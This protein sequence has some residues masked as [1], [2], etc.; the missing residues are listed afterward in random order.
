MTHEQLRTLKD[1]FTDRLSSEHLTQLRK[2]KLGFTF[3]QAFTQHTQIIQSIVLDALLETNEPLLASDPIRL[4]I[5]LSESDFKVFIAKI[6]SVC[7]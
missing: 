7:A 2:R 6:T 3:E 1:L 4:P 5:W